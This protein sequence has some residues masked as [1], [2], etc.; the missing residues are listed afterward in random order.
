[1]IFFILGYFCAQCNYISVNDLF[2]L[3]AI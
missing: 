2:Q 3:D 1:L